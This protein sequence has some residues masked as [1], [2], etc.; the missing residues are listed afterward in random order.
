[1]KKSLSRFM[2]LVAALFAANIAFAG[3]HPEVPEFIDGTK[4]VSAEDLIQLVQSSKELVLVDAR[5]KSDVEKGYI[6]GSISLP[7]TDTN[8]DSLAKIAPNKNVPVV[9]Y[10]NGIHCGR[11]VDSAKVALAAGYKHIYWFRGGMEEWQ[12]KGYPVVKP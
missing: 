4:R 10:C 6:E 1:M 3:D 5:K 2:F 11:S 12:A 8:P 7:N 9:F